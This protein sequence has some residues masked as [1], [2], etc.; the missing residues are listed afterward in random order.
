MLA[1]VY[2]LILAVVGIVVLYEFLAGAGAIGHKHLAGFAAQGAVKLSVALLAGASLLIVGSI[3]T[4][5][6][7]RSALLV[8]PLLVVVVVGCIGEVV[9]LVGTASTE[10]DLVGA[11]I[12]ILAALPV[13][14]VASESRV[15]SGR[16]I[17]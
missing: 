12:L 15:R 8:W 9:D 14:L 10:S 2:G 16:A 5:R 4:L 1:A 6:S 3:R 11:G 13:L 7:T 17:L